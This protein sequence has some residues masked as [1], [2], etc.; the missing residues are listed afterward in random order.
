MLEFERPSFETLV[1]GK[2]PVEGF[3]TVELK[4]DGH[5]CLLLLEESKYEIWS[6]HGKLKE[7]GELEIPAPGR[8]VLHGE[9]LFGTEWAK[10]RPLLYNQFHIFGASELYGED[11]TKFTVRSVR[12]SLENE[13]LPAIAECRRIGCRL[14][15]IQGYP[16]AEAERLWRDFVIAQKYEGLIFRN[17]DDGTWGGRIARM[18]AET[19]ED[20]VCMG[21]EES[22]SD[23]YFGW[24]VRSIKGGL[25]ENGV[26]VEKVHV[27]GIDDDQRREFFNNPGKYVNQ[28][29]EARGKSLTKKG[30]LRH[31]EWMRWRADK[32]PKE[33]VWPKVA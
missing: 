1:P 25:Y 31:P 5:N 28:V 10:D 6:R 15:L 13:L 16:V 27:G 30:C 26:L 29:F 12:G 21:F 17:G 4:M 14:R 24:G 18:K 23:R 33:C 9:F 3:D 22:T 32:L 7:E 2:F 20:Y 19:T 11:A 8:S